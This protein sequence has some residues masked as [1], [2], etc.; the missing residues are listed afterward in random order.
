[1]QLKEYLDKYGITIRG[2]ANRCGC[3]AP[4]IHNIINRKFD[5]RLGLAL[6][7]EKISN[8]EVTV[9]DLAEGVE[10]KLLKRK[11][12]KTLDKKEEEE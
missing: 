4:T 11:N 3:T 8:K 10:R 6:H 1:M 5:I 12:F 2:F 9:Y 7:I